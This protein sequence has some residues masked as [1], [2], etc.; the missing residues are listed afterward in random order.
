[1]METTSASHVWV[2]LASVVVAIPALVAIIA[3]VRSRSLRMLWKV[4]WTVVLLVPVVG[5]VVW[6]AVRPTGF[7]FGGRGASVDR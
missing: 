5:V 1:M 4:I 7:T 3:T 6:L 2:L